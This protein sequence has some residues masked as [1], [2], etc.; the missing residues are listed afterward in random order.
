MTNTPAPQASGT[1]AA[2]PTKTPATYSP[3]P[4]K[5][6]PAKAPT[7]AKGDDEVMST[8]AKKS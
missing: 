7:A 3:T 8:P 6:A 1:P 2:D 4:A 5:D